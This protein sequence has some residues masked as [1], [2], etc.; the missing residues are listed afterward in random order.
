[1]GKLKEL[2]INA[3]SSLKFILIFYYMII[4]A[5]FVSF[6]LVFSYLSLREYNYNNLR[7][8]MLS[9]SQYASELYESYSS[10][11]TLSDTVINERFEF[12]NNMDGQI[13]L[14]DNNATIMYDNAGAGVVGETAINPDYIFPNNRSYNFTTDPVNNE[15]AL[16]YPI[17]INGNQIG[18]IK[19]ITSLNHVN[20]DI[21]RRTGVFAIFSVLSLIF[22]LVLLYFFGNKFLRPINKLKALASKLSDGQYETKSNMNYY[23]EIGELAK[24]MD[25]LSDNI[26]EKEQLKND[27]ISSISHELRTPLTSIKGWALTLQDSSIDYETRV[28]GLNIIETEADRLTDMVEDLLDFSRFSSPSFTLNKTDFDLIQIVK[29]IVRQMKPRA[30]DKEIDLI[31]DYNESSVVLIADENRLKQV[32]INLIDNAIKFTPRGGS[33]VVAINVS[34]ENGLV[35]CEVIDSG[36]G[37]SKEEIKLVTTKFYK[38]FSE[39]S[40]TGL[41]L[42][43]SE[44]IILKHNGKLEIFSVEGEGTKVHFEIP[45]VIGGENEKN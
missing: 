26:L 9:Q 4:F 40:R 16:Y 34:Y 17:N 20:D 10:S 15:M 18:V 11:Y 5:A 8:N 19:S 23:G 1:M 37:I 25:E 6:F 14:L 32:F 45:L 28:D 33:I 43:I 3:K 30:V 21:N 35:T 24:T 7:A 2:F 41:G 27:F 36:I 31:F 22:G 13:Q 12:L 42:S 29:N 44:E 39:G 38:G